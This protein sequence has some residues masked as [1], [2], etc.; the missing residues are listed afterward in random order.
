MS[1]SLIT[2]YNVPGPRYTSYPTV[3]YWE[4]SPTE[5]TWKSHVKKAFTVSG[6]TGAGLSL[7]IHLPYCEKLCTYCG[8][9]KR[10]TINHKVEEPYIE[11]LLK[12]WK[13]YLALFGE[14]PLIK[15]IHL[16]GGTPTFFSPE[17]LRVLIEGLFENSELA[18]QPEMSFEG[19]PNNTTEDHLQTLYD[20]GFRR[21]S[22][23]IQDFDEKVQRVI[24]RIQPYEN[25]ERVTRQAKEI[26]YTS[27]NFDL[28]YGLP[29]QTLDSIINTIE[30]V[31]ILQP[32]RIAFYSY[33]HV[34]WNSPG[35]R[36]YT[37]ADLPKNEEKRTLYETGKALLEEAGYVEIGMDHFAKKTDELYIASQNRSLYRN[38]MGYSSSPTGL[39]IGLGSSSISD[40]WTAFGQNLKKIE[41]YKAAVNEGRFPIFRGHLLTD[42]DLIIRQHILNL[43][44]SF[45]TNW[46]EEGTYT[47]AI[48]EG[49][50]R[51]KDIEN[52]NLIEID[53]YKITVR[54]EGK[55]FIRNICM[56]LD[57]RL[58]R[59]K[60]E[61]ELFSSTV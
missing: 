41:D 4:T 14:K 30:K 27:I 31:K 55:P 18:D 37:E 1:Q 5:E 23:G 26:G 48:M 28:I 36:S 25:V 24:H 34:P 50:E 13:M 7:Y 21:V 17:N 6:I 10:I 33:A 11:T 45:H 46:D 3:P 32:D 12:E 49:L 20:L 60:P 8:C 19:H 57:A 59:N 15:E 29:L 39:L 43:M 44:C 54:E 22:F 38:F 51:L 52:D 9:N 58:W 56:A 35:Q 42:E 47:P 2:K 16:G 61:T 53:D 40:T